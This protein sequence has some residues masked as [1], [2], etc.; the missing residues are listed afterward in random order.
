MSARKAKRQPEAQHD[1]RKE[2][3][4]EIGAALNS[5]K[6]R[7]SCAAA[8]LNASLA[9]DGCDDAARARCVVEGCV[10]ELHALEDR[11]DNLSLAHLRQEAQS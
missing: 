3:I 10:S 11:L 1:Q 6:C 9:V 7:L 4:R 8:A 5:T 2:A